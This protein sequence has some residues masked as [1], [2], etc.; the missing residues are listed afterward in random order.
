MHE[1][2]SFHIKRDSFL[3]RLNPLTKIVVI[4]TI[5]L[6]SFTFPN[7]W[8]PHLL[9]IIAIL[10]LSLMGKVFREFSITAL[11]LIIPT[12]GFLFLMQAFFQP[13]GETVIF[14]F[15][16]LDMTLE[17]VMFAFRNAMR[18]VVMVSGFTI[19]LLT[20]HP[21]ELMSD[22]TRRGLPG[23]F[24]YVIISTLQILPQMQAKAQTIIS[25]QRS[26]GLDTESSFLKR[27]GSLI[28]LIGPLVFGSLVEVEERAIAI[29][30]RGFTSKQVK[31]SLHEIPDTASEKTLRLG[32]LA[33]IVISIG[34]NLW[35]S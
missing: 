7:Y 17:S 30:A 10:P 23:Q 9:L 24:A 16:F 33:L 11:R 27:A 3:H 20:T 1:R 18:I 12:A 35:L 5:I 13:L 19:F 15:Y 29:E 34:L 25:A 8:T 32:L 21:S 4:L 2:L 22:L 26:R 31:T 14:K 28:P 6:L